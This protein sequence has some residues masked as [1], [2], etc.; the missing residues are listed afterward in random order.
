MVMAALLLLTMVVVLLGA[1][2]GAGRS[3]HITFRPEQIGVTLDDV[4]GVD[5]VKE[6]VVRSLNL[7]LA[8]R[9]FT[10]EM[11]GTPRRG[12]LF[13]GLPGTGKT[14]MAKAMA[15][16]AGVPFLFVSATAFQSMY[17]GATARKIR[18]YFRAL[19]KAARREGGAIGFIEEIDAI[20]MTRAVAC[21]RC[22]R[23]PPGP[24]TDPGVL[25]AAR[26]SCGWSTAPT[27]PPS[28]A[29]PSGR[30][31]DRSAREPVAWST[32]C[33]SRCSRS[34]SRAAASGSTPGCVEQLNALLPAHRQLPPACPAADERAGHR[35][36]EPGRHPRPGAAASWPLR[37]SAHVRP[38]RPPGA[39]RAGRPLP[40]QQGP[41]TGA[42]PRGEAREQ[43]AALTQSY[44]PV[45]IEHLL[46]E[47]LVNALRRGGHAMTMRDV[48]RA[49]LT[50]EIGLGQPV[51]T[52]SRS[53]P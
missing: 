22:P 10:R 2:I 51:P 14:H 49:R 33:S 13:E 28:T 3:P 35:G 53:G 42:G 47:A 26:A 43:L 27:A 6:D 9:T 16:E 46:D 8:H 1:T 12:L 41:R 32:S 17:Y 5:A 45:M 30:P 23:R 40:G 38:A 52:P 4:K 21:L 29:Q 34:T 19:R 36:D 15:R 44:T 48:E 50:E 39:P 31:V 20:A 25:A 11:G 24:R 7:F 37:P 18:S